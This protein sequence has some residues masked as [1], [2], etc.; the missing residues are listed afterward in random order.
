MAKRLLSYWILENDLIPFIELLSEA[1]NYSFDE[2][3]E[4]AIQLGV[5]ET[6]Y[7]TELWYEYSLETDSEIKLKLAKDLGTDVVFFEIYG[8]QNIIDRMSI[9]LDTI[10]HLGDRKKL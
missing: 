9:I 1:S 4:T 2:N 6:D 10:N 5:K 3:D 8:P 7:E